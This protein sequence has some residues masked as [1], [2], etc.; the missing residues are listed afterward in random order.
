MSPHKNMIILGAATSFFLWAGLSI[1]ATNPWFFLIASMPPALVGGYY[2]L[3]LA[4]YCYITDIRKDS[5]RA[6]HLTWLQIAISVGQVLG[7]LAGPAIF[8]EFGYAA[9][10]AT[11]SLS[12]ILA[13][14]YVL[15]TVPESVNQG[16]AANSAEVEQI[17]SAPDDKAK[18]P[19][20]SCCS[21]FDVTLAK[22]M[23]VACTKKREGYDRVIIW[24]CICC[25]A[26][27]ICSLVKAN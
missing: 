5:G 24:C 26:V 15:F 10:F 17:E 16:V 13:T 23:F 11:A 21:L 25:L 7:N 18:N 2:S 22:D 4:T 3:I 20:K 8:K 27:N 14:L 9:V 12:N 19:Q 6:W 1:L